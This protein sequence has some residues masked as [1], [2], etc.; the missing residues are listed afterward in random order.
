MAPKREIFFN[1]IGDASKLERAV[2]KATGSLGKVETKT[3]RL[4][5]KMNTF[6]KGLTAGVTLPVV[7]AFGVGFKSLIENETLLAQTQAV[8]DSTGGAAGTSADDV[9]GLANELS[10]LSGAAHESIV[11][12]QNMLLTFTNIRNEAGEGNDVFDQSTKTLL[13]MSTAT[14]QDMQSAAVQLGKAL[15]DPIAGVAALNRVGVQFTDEQKEQIKVLQES[16]DVMGAQ[17]IIL[18]E[19]EG[20]F[21]GSAEA[22]GDTMA[23]SIN[24]L[25]NSFEEIA[26]SLASFLVPILGALAGL[27]SSVTSWFNNLSPG[28]KSLVGPLLGVAAAVG[29]VLLIGEKL[30]TSFGKIQDAYGKLSKAMAKHP[31]VVI[32]LATIAIVTLIVANWDKIKAFLLAIWE[33]IKGAAT[34][35]WDFVKGAVE[36]A[37]NFVTDLFLNFTG[38]GLLIKHWDT[39]REGIQGVVNFFTEKWDAVVTFFTGL[40]DRIFE[41]ASDIWTEVR[42]QIQSVVDFFTEKWDGIVTFFEELPGKIFDTASDIWDEVRAQIQSVIDFFKEQWDG[43]VTFYTGLPGRIT[44]AAKGMWDGITDAFKG[45]VNVIIRAW[46]RLKFTIGGQHVSL[47]F[48]L[49]F[50][51]PTVTLQLPAIKELH[52]GGIF[53]APR[54]GG[55]GLALLKDR[56]RVTPADRIEPFGDETGRGLVIQLIVDGKVL[57]ESLIAHEAAIA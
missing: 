53:R 26:R 16:G 3:D 12:G 20:Q 25:K 9:L 10:N 30:V 31:Y 5:A 41:T 1:F 55:E 13:D 14:G 51:I 36:T 29:P 45:A 17:K 56:E 49:G 8:I 6:G 18:A 44:E 27:L 2:D 15:N 57:A 48:G 50:D 34:A 54:P 38:P 33:A 47:P 46:N 37:I 35:A 11:E 7:A 40:P 4:A 24:R 32:I 23:G 28:V 21:G 52:T 19:L 42:A 39:I 43:I 22:A